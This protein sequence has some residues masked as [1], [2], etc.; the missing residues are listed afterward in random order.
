MYLA[1]GEYDSA[2][3]LSQRLLGAAEATDRTGTVIEI[4]ILR[5]IAFQGR[6]DLVQALS[7]LERAI[8]LAEPAR[9]V[10]VF[11]DEGELMARLLFQARVHHLGT[12]YLA[13]L[14]SALPKGSETAMPASQ[15]LVEPLSAREL[16]VLKLI[17]AGHSNEEIASKLIISVKTVKRHISNIYGKLGV[18]SR[19]QAVALA[20]ELKLVA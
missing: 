7:T 19:T 12:L 3:A 18:K 5:A 16:E 13:E 1:Q 11:L 15:P 4:H 10:R 17:A 20:R 6:R 9:C 2:L 8:A 14:L